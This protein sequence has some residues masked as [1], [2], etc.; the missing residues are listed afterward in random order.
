MMGLT[1]KPLEEWPANNQR[2][3]ED[4]CHWLWAGG[5]SDST[6]YLYG[7]AAR[8]ALSWLDKDYRLIDPENDFNRLRQ[9]IHDH[10]ES[11]A[12]CLTYLKG[13]TKLAEYLRFRCGWPEPEPQVNWAYSLDPLP[14]W[15]AADVRAYITL[16]QRN[17]LAEEQY[18]ATCTLLSHLTLSLRWMVER[19]ALGSI[20]DLTPVLWLDYVDARLDAG[21]QSSTLNRE[22]RDLQ[23]FLRFLADEGRPVCERMLRVEAQKTG[24]RLPRDLSL[25][26]LRRLLRQIEAE[27]AS[28][29]PGNQRQALL[30]RAW[31]L[32]MLHSGLRS[33][34]L[35]RLRL[36]DLDTS[37]SLPSA[38][39]GTGSA[40]LDDRRVRIEQSKGLKDRTVCLSVEAAEAI[41]AYLEVRGPAA[42]DH[43]FLYRHHPLNST[44][45]GK[46]L[47]TL[48]EHDDARAT[49]HQL[50][51]SCATLLLNA[52]ASVLTVQALLGHKHV[53][54]TLRYARVY[55]STVAADY[56]R[57]VL[58]LEKSYRPLSRKVVPV[59]RLEA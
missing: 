56:I 3:Y 49:P 34:E 30:D 45:C 24:A 51:C 7:I 10:Y 54:T 43:V 47:R 11:E 25:D 57:T 36:S 39:L 17:W 38:S 19:V 53:D 32:L 46:R 42:S 26:Q 52:G 2:F 48:D 27:V 31:V 28:G 13:V 58:S 9:A 37:T 12:T 16:R 50:R 59:C 5:Y 44:Y 41:R 6:V 18:R 1:V 40:G 4:F 15:L 55:D 29:Q 21:I 8:L 22:L 20:E 23:H 14:D 33:G 35:R